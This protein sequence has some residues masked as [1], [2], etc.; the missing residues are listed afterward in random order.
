MS[1]IYETR[2]FIAINKPA[3]LLVH[4]APKA[5]SKF[6][7]PNSKE[8]TLVD[9]ILE[10]YPEVKNVGDE[11]ETRPGI[12]HRLDRDTSGVILI[13]RN[14]EFFEY[15]KNLFKTHQIKKTYLAL[16]WGKLEPKTGI[17]EKPIKLKSGS[18][19][20]TVWRGKIEKEA[21][22]KY[23]VIKYLKYNIS[24]TIVDKVLYFSFLEVIPKTGRTHQIRVHLA[25][26]GHPV[27]GDKLYGFKKLKIPFDLDRQFLHAASLEFNSSAGHRIKIEAGLPDDLKRVI[28]TLNRKL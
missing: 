15:L 18:V 10:K 16:V 20:R 22:T 2:D 26:I 13:A 7:I 17:I 24:L 8:P 25:S 27:V 1:L 3:G 12:V 19:K 5:N 4:S 11:P 9:W 14:Q 21:K 28:D 23:K 6:Q